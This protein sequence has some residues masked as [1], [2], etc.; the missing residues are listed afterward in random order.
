MR[1]TIDQAKS[2]GKVV[3][4][5]HGVFDPFHI[6]HI[7]QLERARGLGDV[8]VVTLCADRFLG[9]ERMAHAFNESSR[10][11]MLASLEDTIITYG[12]MVKTRRPLMSQSLEG[13][14]LPSPTV[15]AAPALISRS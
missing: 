5:V 6:G 13:I 9:P 11:E 8:L 10:V 7:R 15:L 14:P 3:A 4:H 1:E 12:Q 2:N